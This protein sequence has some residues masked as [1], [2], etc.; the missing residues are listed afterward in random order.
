MKKNILDLI[1]IN[2]KPLGIK[3]EDDNAL[4]QL[5]TKPTDP[6]PFK[7]YKKIR[8]IKDTTTSVFTDIFFKNYINPANPVEIRK[9]ND[10][11][12][13]RNI[14][15]IYVYDTIKFKLHAEFNLF[16][17]EN[18]HEILSNNED[19]Y[20]DFIFKGGNILFTIYNN[21]RNRYPDL[22]RVLQENNEFSTFIEDNFKIS[23]FDFSIF[24]K[25]KSYKKY[26]SIKKL[27]TQF[28]IL[29]L[30]LINLFFNDMLSK[31][32]GMIGKIT[33]DNVPIQGPNI[34]NPPN[35]IID[36]Q[37][38][39][40]N[41]RINTKLLLTYE[42]ILA[43]LY[44]NK[45][46]NI[47]MKQILIQKPVFFGVRPPTMNEI[48]L[49]INSVN[50]YINHNNNNL[51][52]NNMIILEILESINDINIFL[53][54]V[55]ADYPDPSIYT[56][57]NLLNI[58][59]ICDYIN[60]KYV[61]VQIFNINPVRPYFEGIKN[62]FYMYF[63]NLENYIN[64]IQFYNMHDVSSFISEL[65]T[66]LYRTMVSN[67][68]VGPERNIFIKQPDV[69]DTLINV[70]GGI[71]NRT[72][73]CFSYV[74][75]DN[76]KITISNS[77]ILLETNNNVLVCD[78]ITYD[79]SDIVLLYPNT[80]NNFHYLSYNSSI[81]QSFN[82]NNCIVNFDLLRTKVNVILKD[83]KIYT[84]MND[85]PKSGSIKIPS[86]FIDI[87]IACYEDTGNNFTSSSKNKVS[88]KINLYNGINVTEDFY[89]E[90][91]S[92]SYVIKDLV[93]MLFNQPPNSPWTDLKY[94]KRL[95]RLFFLYHVEDANNWQ[96]MN[97]IQNISSDMN[98]YIQSNMMNA[99]IFANIL[100]SFLYDN[101][102]T[103]RQDYIDL[104][105]Y[106]YDKHL[107][108]LEFKFGKIDF[109]LE[110]LDKVINI[111]FYLFII[112]ILYDHENIDSV[113]N[114]ILFH[115]HNYIRK[116]YN[117]IEYDRAQFRTLYINKIP[118][119]INNLNE[120]LVDINNY[121]WILN[122]IIL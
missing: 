108:I 80:N 74:K 64:D 56:I 45:S 48:T 96:Y 31:A 109:Y 101:I 40:N 43:N 90:G 8:A 119:F 38:N 16:L 18:G 84:P 58:Y 55:Q 21:L 30:D 39:D 78:D 120:A 117:L 107:N 73:D 62:R 32:T 87:S 27:L 65:T 14:F 88:Y 12:R 76:N 15:L 70:E 92:I 82:Q 116:I 89:I 54:R 60:K 9:Q 66:S 72:L 75:L 102:G 121:M 24:I 85:Q 111:L 81:Y 11:I 95:S 2:T 33:I 49:L 104:I 20:I 1:K 46:F 41:E 67:N 112:Y 86:E 35:P 37:I 71:N 113:N 94:K 13:R 114:N 3:L 26:V 100:P 105:H 19:D 63:T 99:A 61:P 5:N 52:F 34:P 59:N 51:I 57:K 6:A 44:N 53:G 7:T 97:I 36:R 28:L 110:G 98:I 47:L 42:N 77:D 68:G 83:V 69:D 91:Y 122:N 25:T 103:Y 118:E 23:D 4:H 115:Y 106:M 17:M 50:N 29:K 93:N 10:N 22:R 79:Q